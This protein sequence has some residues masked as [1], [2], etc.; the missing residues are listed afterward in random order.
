MLHSQ[1]MNRAGVLGDYYRCVDRG[2]P[3]TGDITD[4]PPIGDC[5]FETEFSALHPVPLFPDLQFAR[6]AAGDEH[7]CGILWG[8]SGRRAVCWVRGGRVRVCTEWVKRD[9]QDYACFNSQIALTVVTTAIAP[10]GS[11]RHG[12]LSVDPASTVIARANST[13]P[14]DSV[15]GSLTPIEVE[16][17]RFKALAAGFDY[18]CGLTDGGAL[19]CW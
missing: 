8:G 5:A 3:R 15:V 10:Q 2:S 13:D 1:G 19:V 17:Y 16:G 12:Q 11:N 14:L 4:F 7:A 6:L 9:R 18:T